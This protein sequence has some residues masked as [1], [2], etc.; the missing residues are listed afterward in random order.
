MSL[1]L[2]DNPSAFSELHRLLAKPEPAANNTAHER[3]NERR[4]P[5]CRVQLLAPCIGNRMPASSDFRQVQC[6]DLSPRGF[7]YVTQQPPDFEYLIVALGDLPFTFFL[8]EVRHVLSQ[9]QSADAP[10]HF[11]VGCRFVRRVC[12]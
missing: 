9:R 4:Y 6:R 11:L 3:R 1:A 7:S 8:A 2:H 12:G 5:F 10:E